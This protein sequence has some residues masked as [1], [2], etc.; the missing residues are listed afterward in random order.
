MTMDLGLASSSAGLHP[1]T[2]NFWYL[3]CLALSSGIAEE[4][5]T[6]CPKQKRKKFIRRL[7]PSM[8]KL[9]I[10]LFTF[11]VA[12]ALAM[13]AFAQE[14]QTKTETTTTTTTKLMTLHGT[15]SDDGKTFTND[16]DQ[17]AWTVRNP[18][19]LKGHEGHH[20]SV[21]AHVYADKGEIH[22]VSVRMV[23]ASQTTTTKT[24]TKTETTPAPPQ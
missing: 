12:F 22:V 9:L 3:S 13:P 24:E 23:K 17:K 15:V 7:R 16:K 20:V 2:H 5:P 18:E 11:T 14:T 8:K 19:A 4:W 6:P 21:K 1:S 10:L